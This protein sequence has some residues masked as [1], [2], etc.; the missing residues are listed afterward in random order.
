[1]AQHPD[2]TRDMRALASHSWAQSGNAEF[3]AVAALAIY[4]LSEGLSKDPNGTVA[5]EMASARLAIAFDDL[6]IAIA[7]GDKPAKAALNIARKATSAGFRLPAWAN[8]R[9]P[10]IFA[11]FRDGDH[12][13]ATRL[14][15]EAYRSLSGL[16]ADMSDKPK[17]EREERDLGERIVA[18]LSRAEDQGVDVVAAIGTLKQFIEGA[19][20]TVTPARK[21]YKLSDAARD[22][23]T[24]ASD[25]A[26]AA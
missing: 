11:A 1:M 13:E 4:A 23:L 3:R 19:T 16:L 21:V 26:S 24:D 9:N 8:N 22:S 18:M 14:L 10:A 12:T 7:R 25:M 17:A 15:A 5:R 6:T 2:L 20:V